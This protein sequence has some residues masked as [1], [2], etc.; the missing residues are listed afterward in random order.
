MSW[1][2]IAV[3]VWAALAVSLALLIGRSIRV[4]EVLDSGQAQPIVPD[5]FPAEWATPAAGS[6]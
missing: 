6:R 1:L 3:A 4:A 2:L 5:F